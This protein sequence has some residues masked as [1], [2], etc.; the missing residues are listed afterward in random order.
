MSD[1]QRELSGA[2]PAAAQPVSPAHLIPLAVVAIAAL[3]LWWGS[4]PAEGWTVLESVDAERNDGQ[5]LDAG[6]RF[7]FA[8]IRTTGI[9]SAD[10]QLGETVRVVVLPGSKVELPP[11]PGR[12]VGRERAVRVAKGRVLITTG[13][14]PPD[15]RL[16]VLTPHSR[17]QVGAATFSVER[18]PAGTRICLARGHIE[19]EAP[20]REIVLSV[21]EGMQLQLYSGGLEPEIGSQTEEERARL[22]AVDR[23]GIAP[24]SAMRRGS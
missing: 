15:Y 11:G 3:A 16:A 23:A 18:I 13:D 21:P 24:R 10:L 2:P 6:D 5:S 19:T 4:R 20:A 9:G 7:P 22:E 8:T 17:T 1:S 12:W 14:R